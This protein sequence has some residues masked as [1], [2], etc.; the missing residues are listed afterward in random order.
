MIKP[1]YS[2]MFGLKK[3]HSSKVS[4]LQPE[5]RAEV[6][7]MISKSIKNIVRTQSIKK[8]P[9][10]LAQELQLLPMF[11]Q[12]QKVIHHLFDFGLI[13][14]KDRIWYIKTQK[15]VDDYLDNLDKVTIP[16]SLKTQIISTINRRKAEIV[17]WNVVP[18]KYIEHLKIDKQNNG[19]IPQSIFPIVL[20]LETQ[21]MIL[22]KGD[23]LRNKTHFT[24]TQKE[25]IVTASLQQVSTF[26]PIQKI[27]FSKLLD[28]ILTKTST[29]AELIH[30]PLFTI[31]TKS[32]TKREKNNITLVSFHEFKK[33]QSIFSPQTGRQIITKLED[34]SNPKTSVKS[35]I[36]GTNNLTK[37]TLLKQFLTSPGIELATL[38]TQNHSL[39]INE[40][41]Y[42][43][44]DNARLKAFSYFEKTHIPSIGMDIGLRF[45][46]VPDAFQPNTHVKRVAGVHEGDTDKILYKKMI[47]YYTSMIKKYSKIGQINAEIGYGFSLFDGYKYTDSL[48]YQSIILSALPHKKK[49]ITM[50]LLSLI[51][52][53]K[54]G[55]YYFDLNTHEMNEFYSQ[56]SEF[57][58]KIFFQM[59]QADSQD[60]SP[61]SIKTLEYDDLTFQQ[62]HHLTGDFQLIQQ[63]Q[64]YVFHPTQGKIIPLIQNTIIV[65]SL[66]HQVEHE[67]FVN[68]Y[69]VQDLTISTLDNSIDYPCIPLG[70]FDT[71]YGEHEIHKI[72][73][74]VSSQSQTLLGMMNYLHASSIEE[75]IM[76]DEITP[77]QRLNY[78]KEIWEQNNQDPHCLVLL[79]DYKANSH[80]HLISTNGILTFENKVNCEDNFQP[81]LHIQQHIQQYGYFTHE[82]KDSFKIK[83]T[84]IESQNHTTILHESGIQWQ[85]I[86]NEIGQKIGERELASI[87]PLAYKIIANT[88]LLL[89]GK[90]IKEPI[91]DVQDFVY[92]EIM[93]KLLGEIL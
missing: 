33:A 81:Q 75:Y 52:D 93:R 66:Y 68:T 35:I 41:G 6:T 88:L 37:I 10:K 92:F 91:L 51:I 42:N 54:S 36:I 32:L 39:E 76:G 43:E 87:D 24:Y 62:K 18:Q 56:F 71:K 63:G 28:H 25:S 5:N 4:S 12:V 86:R 53:P 58:E 89:Q 83:K 84:T 69:S 61:Q 34:K 27:T 90:P 29:S 20:D 44:I 65:D 74:C 59:Y 82:N 79:I 3:T 57:R 19:H 8:T 70:Y 1:L 72:I 73:L 64:K 78:A 15:Q 60:K 49:I 31:D 46:G 55:K 80:L 11:E 14:V 45:K 9:H 30:L 17:E 23:V 85:H 7:E 16:I 47:T 38:N 67:G 2:K 50:P 40:F 48:I 26:L 77:E 22:A 21:K 13:Y